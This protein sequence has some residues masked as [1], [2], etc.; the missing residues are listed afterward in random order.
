MN[1]RQRCC[2]SRFVFKLRELSKPAQI[3]SIKKYIDKKLS[4]LEENNKNLNKGLKLSKA[5]NDDISKNQKHLTRSEKF[6]KYRFK[7]S[8]KP[9]DDFCRPK[10]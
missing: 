8:I 10:N 9:R 3:S 7:D 2:K 1:I 5:K 6:R 4:T